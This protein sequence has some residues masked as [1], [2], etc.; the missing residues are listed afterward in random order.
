MRAASANLPVIDLPPPDN[1]VV[2]GVQTTVPNVAGMDLASA[3]NA[4][5][6][7]GFTPTQGGTSFSSYAPGT[8]AFTTPGGFSQAPEGSQVTIITSSGAAPPP[9][10]ATKPPDQAD[11]QGED[12]GEN[13]H[14]GKAEA[15][16]ALAGRNPASAG[17][18]V[19]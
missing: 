14:E 4:L 8:V 11:D 19:E 15:G 6:A 2:L 12:A 3:T 1:S 10:P 18:L 7:A 13:S 5:T 17:K 16:K 9:P